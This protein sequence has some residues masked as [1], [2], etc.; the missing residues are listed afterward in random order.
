M[1]D[2]EGSKTAALV[3]LM[4]AAAHGRTRAPKFADPTALTLLPDDGRAALA[5]FLAGTPLPDDA[6]LHRILQMRAE[7]MVTL[8]V[9]LDEAVR[10][11]MHALLVRAGFSVTD[12]RDFVELAAACGASLAGAGPRLS[13]GRVAVADR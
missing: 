11:R 5:R 8:T 10:E 13:A 7:V 12:D 6:L 3:C 9:A 4:R 2:G 1:K